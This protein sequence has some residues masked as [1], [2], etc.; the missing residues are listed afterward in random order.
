MAR[1]KQIQSSQRQHVE[2]HESKLAIKNEQ[3]A[4]QVVWDNTQLSFMEMA[5]LQK[6]SLQSKLRVFD[7]L[8]NAFHHSIRKSFVK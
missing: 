2:L 6:F 8:A 4:R 1:E 5:R 3:L 7:Q